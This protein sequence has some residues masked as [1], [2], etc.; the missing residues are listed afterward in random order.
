M[1]QL[2]PLTTTDTLVIMIE[3]L[4]KQRNTP[5]SSLINAERLSG[6]GSLTQQVYGLLSDLI[7]RLQ[8]V[9]NRPLSEKEVAECLALSKTPVREAFINLAENGLVQVIPKSGTYV[10]PISLNRA[11]EG[12]FVRHALETECAQR[13]AQ[14]RSFEDLC[15]LKGNLSQQENALVEQ[16]YQDFYRLDDEFHELLFRTADVP[17]ARRFVAI[18]KLEIDR[19]R[20]LKL[21][22][23]MRRVEGVLEEHTAIVRAVESKDADAA[24]AA[25]S[26]HIDSVKNSIEAVAANQEFWDLCHTVNQDIPRRRRPKPTIG[27]EEIVETTI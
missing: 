9:P 8:L 13:V 19:I 1:L 23:A 14:V 6:E 22:T 7:I 16:R 20:N 25:M 12:Y 4:D 5:L 26:L 3:I 18:A 2:T 27:L 17:T 10:S 15:R 11:Y 21:Q 24:R